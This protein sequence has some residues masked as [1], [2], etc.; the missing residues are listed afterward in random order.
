[1]TTRK[2][3]TGI[4]LLATF[5]SCSSLHQPAAET[6]NHAY[7]QY[8]GVERHPG[9]VR[10]AVK[11]LIDMKGVVTSAGSEYLSR[12]SP[13]AKRDAKCLEI[14]RARGVDF[15]GKTNTTEFAVGVSG[16]NEYFGTP[17]NPLTKHG[18]LIPGGSSSGSAVA[19]ASGSAD[20]AFGTDTC[21]SIR[22]PA[23]CCGVYGLK[24]TFGLISLAG[25]YPIAPNQLDTVGPLAKDLPH[26]VQGMDLLESG[27]AGK[28]QAAVAAKP[29]AHSIKIGRLYLDGTD[30]KIDQAIDAALAS[31]GFQVVNL[32]EGFKKAWVQAEKDGTTIASVAAWMSDRK[33]TT[34]PGILA[35][36]KAVVTL[37]A[38]EYKINYPQALRRQPAWQALVKQTL[39]HV[40]FI[41]LPVLKTLPPTLP[42]FG[43]TALFEAKILGIQA[44]S[45]ANLAGNPAIAI[46]IPVNDKKVPLTSMQLLGPARGE[47]QLLNAARL[48]SADPQKK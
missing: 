37:G 17:R 23:A 19:V 14:A 47:A 2:L 30:P 5:T 39:H 1:M 36:T 18:R 12:N 26:L 45:A 20:V 8:W 34:E 22:V 10:L 13:P 28:Y 32:G 25:V 35:R 29:S 27:F 48:V 3:L 21:G 31:K 43:G 46:P 41:A 44:T 40:D 7:I 24:T 6:R 42:R 15:V 38:V 4:S 11:D 9:K 16:V 33:F